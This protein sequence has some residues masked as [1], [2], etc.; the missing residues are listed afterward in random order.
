M[1][2]AVKSQIQCQHLNVVTTIHHHVLLVNKSKLKFVFIEKLK[3]QSSSMDVRFH[4][5]FLEAKRCAE[6]CLS[7]LKCLLAPATNH[8]KHQLANE[9]L[10]DLEINL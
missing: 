9:L 6:Q 2:L 5:L 7:A 10:V 1:V 4:E 8:V 3:N